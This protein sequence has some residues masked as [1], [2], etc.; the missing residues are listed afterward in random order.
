[1]EDKKFSATCF[2]PETGEF[3]LVDVNAESP[4]EAAEIA[5]EEATKDGVTPI[6][7]TIVMVS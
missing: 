5:A 1:M 3:E 7:D 4:T 6:V 2:F